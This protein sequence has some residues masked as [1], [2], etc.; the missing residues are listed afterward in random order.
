[1][2]HTRPFRLGTRAMIRNYNDLN[3]TASVIKYCKEQG[4]PLL[5][6][7]TKPRNRDSNSSRSSR[8]QGSCPCGEVISMRERHLSSTDE[9]IRR[10]RRFRG[11]LAKTLAEW[12]R[13]PDEPVPGEVI[14]GLIGTHDAP[15][16][17]GT[18]WHFKEVR[19]I[20]GRIE[21]VAWK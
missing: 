12:K 18:K 9:Q 14:C 2:S 16:Q 8:T 6:R 1:V 20:A 4:T 19:S 13:S 5:Y 21:S 17:K 11:E 10:L 3:C 15:S 7:G